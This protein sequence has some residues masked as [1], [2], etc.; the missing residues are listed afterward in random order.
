VAVSGSVSLLLALLGTASQSG[1]WC[2]LVGFPLISAEAADEYGVDLSRLAI[3]P[4]PG[5]GWTT[6]VGALLDAV[7]VVAAR[8]P[9]GRAQLPP[10]DVRRLVSRAR[11]RE[12]VLVSYGSW[13]GADVRLTARQGQWSGIGQGYGRLRARRVDVQAEGRGSAARPRSAE[14]WLPADDGGVELATPLATVIELAG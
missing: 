7:D 8:P 12:A 10:G 11:T 3:V 4:E 5:A 9:S 6:A 14:L 1:A 2:A 13:P